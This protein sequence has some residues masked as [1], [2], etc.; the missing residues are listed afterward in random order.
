MLFSK[1]LMAFFLLPGI[2]GL[3]IPWSLSHNDPWRGNEHIFG[4]WL[5]AIGLF[6]L[7]S[8]VKD[9]YQAGRGT[10]APWSPPRNLVTIGLYRYS[11]NPM[12]IGVLLIITG[13]SWTY[14]SPL[15]AGYGLICAAMFHWRVISYEEKILLQDFPE[16]WRSYAGVVPRWLIRR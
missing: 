8:C 9:F 11:R 10:L 14:A 2:F 15:T 3:L 16:H 12:Y 7:L 6:V 5:T 1:A 4:L 13:F